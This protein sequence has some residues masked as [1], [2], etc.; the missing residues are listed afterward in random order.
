VLVLK[1]QLGFA[2]PVTRLEYQSA[3]LWKNVEFY[4]LEL[5]LC[6]TSLAVLTDNFAR[7]YDGNAPVLVATADP[8]VINAELDDWFGP[9]F[10]RPFNYD[11]SKN[12]IVEIRWQNET[13]GAKANTWAYD[14]GVGRMLKTREYN[15]TTGTLVTT[16]NRFRVT[17]DN[18]AVEGSSLGR[19]R[20]LFR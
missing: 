16:V 9:A 12:L 20:A 13:T 2:A 8:F 14:T 11:K 17:Y 10:S 7:N 19:V 5:R 1:G 15:G 3:G 4:K 6:H 18:P